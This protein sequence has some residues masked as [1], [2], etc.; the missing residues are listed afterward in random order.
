MH[1]YSKLHN[2]DDIVTLNSTLTY[3]GST[4]PPKQIWQLNEPEYDHNDYVRKADVPYGLR[5]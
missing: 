4:D 5:F 2:G 3:I 1:V